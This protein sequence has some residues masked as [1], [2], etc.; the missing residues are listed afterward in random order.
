MHYVLK[1]CLNL[2]LKSLLYILIYFF[3]C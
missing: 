1:A 3:N 2:V